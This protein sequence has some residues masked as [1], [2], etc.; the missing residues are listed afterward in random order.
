L[1]TILPSTTFQ[2]SMYRI[3]TRL[4]V[5]ATP[6]NSPECVASCRPKA[7]AHSPMKSRA[8]STQTLSENAA[9]KGR[10]QLS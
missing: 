4:P 8:S 7:A 10:C 3:S 5:G 9:W 2:K 1:S 6:M